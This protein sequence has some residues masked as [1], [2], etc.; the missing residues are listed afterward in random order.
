[1]NNNNNNN[2]NNNLN[3]KAFRRSGLA[4]NERYQLRS[5]FPTFASVPMHHTAAYPA[6]TGQ[7]EQLDTPT[8]DIQGN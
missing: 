2:N 1:M 8:F 5:C 6:I 3:C 4:S 7:A